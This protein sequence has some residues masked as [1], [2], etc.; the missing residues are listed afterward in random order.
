MVFAIVL[1]AFCVGATLAE[2]ILNGNDVSYDFEFFFLA[3]VLQSR[4]HIRKRRTLTSKLRR[5]RRLV[6]NF[7][8]LIKH[9]FNLPS[10]LLTPENVQRGPSVDWD[11]LTKYSIKQLR[12][13][14]A[15][16]G[17]SC[18]GCSEKSHLLAE[19][20]KARDKPIIPKKAPSKAAAADPS[21]PTDFDPS[22][23]STEEIMAWFNNKKKQEDK[24]KDDLMEKLRAQGFKFSDGTAAR[25]H[26]GFQSCLTGDFHLGLDF[27]FSGGGGAGGFPDLS[28]LKQQKQANADKKTRPEEP[29]DEL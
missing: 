13:I 1:L 6:F 2:G 11:N 5:K 27:Q 4:N 7:T 17:L 12:K 10:K 16:R 15:D 25:Q 8:C 22:K 18:K 9:S 19:V 23:M 14:L 21:A 24:Q 20:T 29:K 26:H 3:T 28:K